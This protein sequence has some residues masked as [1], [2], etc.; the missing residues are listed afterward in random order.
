MDIE[1][2]LQSVRDIYINYPKRYDSAADELRKVENEI[3]DILHVMELAK[4]DAI[5]R[6]YLYGELEKLRKTRRDLKR[7]LELLE[8]IKAF[9]A[10]PKP[11]EKV[12]SHTIGRVRSKIERQKNRTYTMKV[13]KDLQELIK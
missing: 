11:T 10:H 5:K 3:Q 9:I 7:E 2:S 1:Q 4:V 13:R 8:E 6:T 12:I